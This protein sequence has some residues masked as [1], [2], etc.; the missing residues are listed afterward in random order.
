MTFLVY[1]G[2]CQSPTHDDNVIIV[3]AHI[4]YTFIKGNKEYP[5]QIK[6]TDSRTYTCKNYRSDIPLYDFYNNMYTFDEVTV[7]IDGKKIKSIFPQHAYY[8]DQGIFHSD[9]RVCYFSLP[10]PKKDSYGEVKFEKTYLEPYYFNLI[11]LV[12]DYKI[13]QMSVVINVPDWMQIELKEFNFG[14]NEIT[15]SVSYKDQITTYLFKINN[16]PAFSDEKGAP[17]PTYLFPYIMVHSKTATIGDK[18]FTYFN[19]LSDQYNWYKNLVSSINNDSVIVKNQT[20]N[21]V[22]GL[23]DDMDKVK[24]IFQWIQDNIRYIAFEDGIAGFKPDNAQEVLRKKYGDCK[25]MA[26]LMVEMLRSIGLDARKCWIGTR[27]IAHD[28]STPSLSSDNHMICAWIKPDEIV[29][30]DATEKYIGFGEIGERIQGRPTMIEN[31]DLFMIKNIPDRSFTQN[32][33]TEKRSLKIVGQDLSGRVKQ[34]WKGENKEFML[35]GFHNINIDK[36]ELALKS[37]LSEQNKNI[38]ITNLNIVNITDYNKDLEIEYDFVWRNAISTFGD[39]SYIEPDNRRF[40][41]NFKFDLTKRKLPY[42]FD[43]KDHVLMESEIE[44]PQGKLLNT[45]PEKL[46]IDKKGYSFTASYHINEGKLIY[47]NEI[48][49]KDTRLN[50]ADLSQWNKDI[51]ALSAFYNEQI[52]ITHQK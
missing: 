50:L 37:F 40:L 25:G 34:V 17:G 30:L 51:D 43:F 21:I 11:Y 5:V 35:H 39:V 45:L 52:E 24:K 22:S 7:T 9:Q 32:T 10:M 3:N 33:S 49:I 47:K 36:Q 27:H 28:Y 6:E 15:R 26:N 8:N 31:G 2:L 18:T 4:E 44:L 46:S 19:T 1:E 29:Y 20:Q 13:D 14:N 42:L 38:E 12:A 41:E 48:I 16:S 23:T